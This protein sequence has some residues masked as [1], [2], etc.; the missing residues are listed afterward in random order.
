MITVK[1]LKELIEKYPDYESVAI[2]GWSLRI[3]S[4]YKYIWD[5]RETLNSKYK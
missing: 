3:G 4:S 5:M 1:E 2:K